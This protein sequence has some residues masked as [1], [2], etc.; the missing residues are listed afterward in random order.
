MPTVVD[1]PKELDMLQIESASSIDGMKVEDGFEESK[2]DRKLEGKTLLKLD[3]LLIP[4]MCGIYLLAFLDRS[5]IGNARVAGLQEDLG[6]TDNQY[7][8]GKQGQFQVV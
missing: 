3:L 7:K 1:S 8:T 4:M 2:F 5:N 6:L